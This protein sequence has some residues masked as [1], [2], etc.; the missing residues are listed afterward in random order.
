MESYNVLQNSALLGPV[1][2]YLSCRIWGCLYSRKLV[3]AGNLYG[4]YEFRTVMLQLPSCFKLVFRM[5]NSKKGSMYVTSSESNFKVWWLPHVCIWSPSNSDTSAF[6]LRR[7]FMQFLRFSVSPT[8]SSSTSP[9]VFN[10]SSG[11]GVKYY[12]R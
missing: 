12:K 5:N 1:C 11:I 3:P 4:L 10:P 2:F 7:F 8:I 9:R 6:C